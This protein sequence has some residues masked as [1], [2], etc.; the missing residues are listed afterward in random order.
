MGYL[1]VHKGKIVQWKRKLVDARKYVK[2]A[3][4]QKTSKVE[5]YKFVE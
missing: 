1:I 2:K 5:I 3:G 4:P